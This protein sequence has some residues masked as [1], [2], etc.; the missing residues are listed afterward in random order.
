MVVA[1]HT[2]GASWVDFYLSISISLLNLQY[3]MWYT[4]VVNIAKNIALS[5]QAYN[6]F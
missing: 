6:P 1:L 4:Q 3:V 5:R 2:K